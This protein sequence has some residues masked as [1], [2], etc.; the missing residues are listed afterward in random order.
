MIC[1]FV[2]LLPSVASIGESLL[3][4]RWLFQVPAW[5]ESKHRAAYTK[6]ERDLCGGLLVKNTVLK[7]LQEPGGFAQPSEPEFAVCQFGTG[8]SLTARVLAASL[9]IVPK[10]VVEV[11]LIY[12]GGGF[13]ATSTSTTDLILNCLAVSFIIDIDDMM[14][15]LL[16]VPAAKIEF[17]NFPSIGLMLATHL[18]EGGC[19]WFDLL[20]QFLGTWVTYA[21]ITFFLTTTNRI[22]CQDESDMPGLVALFGLSYEEA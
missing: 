16:V 1:L 20:F 3:M 19:Y 22:W 7:Y 18:K 5:D 9:C 10:L 4:C 12:V 13:I 11:L 8:I 17:E 6:T 15:S 2:M 14:Y 21:A